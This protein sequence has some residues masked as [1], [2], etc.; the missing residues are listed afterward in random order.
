MIIW[1]YMEWIY[2]LLLRKSISAISITTHNLAR[3]TNRHQE[4]QGAKTPVELL[5]LKR[6]EALEMQ[7]PQSLQA[8]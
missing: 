2:N 5:V 8:S 6:A 7:T 1:I 3:T 4:S